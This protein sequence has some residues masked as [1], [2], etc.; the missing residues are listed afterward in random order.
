MPKVRE[1]HLSSLET[2]QDLINAFHEN[3]DLARLLESENQLGI[4]K[5]LS[6]PTKPNVREP[7]CRALEFK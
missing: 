7:F 3:G 2:H 1:L 4:N 5:R 6:F